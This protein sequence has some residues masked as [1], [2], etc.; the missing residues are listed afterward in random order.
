MILHIGLLRHAEHFSEVDLDRI[1]N[2]VNIC[3]F[4]LLNLDFIKVV[5]IISNLFL[6]PRLP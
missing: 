2:A 6:L 3:H 4:G 1:L 5:H